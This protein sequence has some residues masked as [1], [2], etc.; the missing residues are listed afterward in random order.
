M[1]PGT[2]RG[3][4]L[5][6]LIDRY[7]AEVAVQTIEAPGLAEAVESGEVDTPATHDLV[8]K[9]LEPL[10]TSGAD[11]L[12]L[13]CTHYAF[14]RDLIQQEA[15]AGVQVIEPSAAVAKQVKRVLAARELLNPRRDGGSVMYLCSG[16]EAAF[17]E[18][19][20]ALQAGDATRESGSPATT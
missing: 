9:L 16:G 7:G 8:R 18:R 19:R 12:A 1:T 5:A 17:A 15:G 10:R 3:Q 13:G 4:K 2:A 6:A 20:A 11:V 14:I